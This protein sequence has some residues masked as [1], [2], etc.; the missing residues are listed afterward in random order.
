MFRSFVCRELGWAH[1]TWN[2]DI[3]GIRC[4][5]MKYPFGRGRDDFWGPWRRDIHM[6]PVFPWNPKSG[7]NRLWTGKTAHTIG[8]TDGAFAFSFPRKYGGLSQQDMVRLIQSRLF[9]TL[10]ER[11][12]ATNGEVWAVKVGEPRRAKLGYFD[13]TSLFRSGSF[14]PSLLEF[15]GSLVPFGAHQ[16]DA[17]EGVAKTSR[18]GTGWPLL[19][20][21]LALECGGGLAPSPE[22]PGPCNSPGPRGSRPPLLRAAMAAPCLFLRCRPQ[23]P[24]PR[25]WRQESPSSN[26]ASNHRLRSTS[27]CPKTN[28]SLDSRISPK[29]RIRTPQHFLPGSNGGPE[30]RI[31]ADWPPPPSQYCC[32]LSTTPTKYRRG[33]EAKAGGERA[34]SFLGALQQCSPGA[35]L[36]HVLLLE[37]RLHLV[38]TRH[39]SP[40]SSSPSPSISPLPCSLHPP[41][42][43]GI[44][45]IVAK[46]PS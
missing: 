38:S 15:P 20:H 41:R 39:L 3:H 46:I 44:S 32:P 1:W 9:L 45:R 34:T 17:S 21:L 11:Q 36:L 6:L 30:G 43:S 13:A 42:P 8:R 10:E 23:L 37:K 14:P 22:C 28:H 24:V 19:Q 31:T 25:S 5:M 27:S 7:N 33:A 2:S 12:T 26:P 16:P 4:D 29:E 40:A 35:R 18:P